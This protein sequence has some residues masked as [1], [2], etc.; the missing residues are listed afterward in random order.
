MEGEGAQGIGELIMYNTSLASIDLRGNNFGDLG[1][2]II[3]NSLKQH[4]NEN[5]VELDMGYNEIKDDGACALAQVFP[6][7]EVMGM[8]L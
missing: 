3:A 7:T 5:L 2:V 6:S 1:A 8:W 4:E